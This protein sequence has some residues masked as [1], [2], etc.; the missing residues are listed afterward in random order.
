MITTKQ[1][2]TDPET[3]TRADAIRRH[4]GLNE[5]ELMFLPDDHP[6]FGLR[7]TKLQA[8]Y[9]IPWAAPYQDFIDA[10]VSFTRV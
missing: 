2:L 8:Q 7:V 1:I 10:G 9:V 6:G 4:R 5:Y 3:V